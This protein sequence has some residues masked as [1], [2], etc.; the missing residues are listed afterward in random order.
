MIAL[1]FILADDPSGEIPPARVVNFTQTVPMPQQIQL[2]GDGRKF[3]PVGSRI[4]GLEAG[5]APNGVGLRE[6]ALELS[7]RARIHAGMEFV[8]PLP[9]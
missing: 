5:G 1:F 3:V 4:G 9:T 7:L 2:A 8:N 6:R